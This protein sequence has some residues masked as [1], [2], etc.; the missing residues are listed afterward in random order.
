MFVYGFCESG[1]QHCVLSSELWDRQHQVQAV[2]G[3]GLEKYVTENKN[4]TLL[5]AKNKGM[6]KTSKIKDD[7]RVQANI[8]ASETED[9]HFKVEIS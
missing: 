5:C 7:W 8:C 6:G 1:G 4:G 3:W 9:K 2:G